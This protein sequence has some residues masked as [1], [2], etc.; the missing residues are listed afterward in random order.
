MT[1]PCSPAR[2]AASRRLLLPQPGPPQAPPAAS[3]L[4]PDAVKQAAMDD[5]HVHNF[6]GVSPF[7]DFG[8]LLADLRTA[9]PPEAAAAALTLEDDKPLNI[10]QVGRERTPCPAAQAVCHRAVPHPHMVATPH[11]SPP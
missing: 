9:A 1:S 11:P 10:L 7:V 4:Q 6:W 5:H 2:A 3:S 8:K